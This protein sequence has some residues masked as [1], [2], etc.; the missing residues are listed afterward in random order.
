MKPRRRRAVHLV[1]PWTSCD[2]KTAA[3]E[4]ATARARLSPETLDKEAHSLLIVGALDAIGA[5]RWVA[6][7]LEERR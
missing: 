5:L 4:A 1:R 7:V 6:S 2:P 3:I